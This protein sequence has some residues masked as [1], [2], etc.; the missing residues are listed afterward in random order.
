MSNLSGIIYKTTTNTTPLDI[1]SVDHPAG[2]TT[3]VFV[4]VVACGD[5]VDPILNRY[6]LSRRWILSD[7]DFVVY[8]PDMSFIDDP[9]LDVAYD[10]S[11]KIISIVGNSGNVF[12]AIDYQVLSSGV[13]TRTEL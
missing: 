7:T 4:K 9:A 1:L 11:T 2:H 5:N 6:Y 13:A 10:P 8:N 3:A 12:W